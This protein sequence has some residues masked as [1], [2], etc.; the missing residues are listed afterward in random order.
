MKRIQS[1]TRFNSFILLV[2]VGDPFYL[3]LQNYQNAII[4]YGYPVTKS[5][6]IKYSAFEKGNINGYFLGNQ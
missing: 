5:R 1:S 6:R 4:L 3:D 2:L